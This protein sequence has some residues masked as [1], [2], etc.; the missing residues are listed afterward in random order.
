MTEAQARNDIAAII[1]KAK[2]Q[3]VELTGFS[4]PSGVGAKAKDGGWGITVQVMEK[5]SIPEGMDLLGI[6]EVE[7]D[8]EGKILGY[9]RKEIRRRGDV[10]GKEEE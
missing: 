5:Q 2:K 7:T 3:L 9:E 6:Y 8:S 1:E 10:M 4:S